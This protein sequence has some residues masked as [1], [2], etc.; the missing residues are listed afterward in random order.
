MGHGRGIDESIR[1]PLIEVAIFELGFEGG[2]E[3]QETGQL[4]RA[5]QAKVTQNEGVA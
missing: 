1:E 5:P 4:R 3:V 2:I